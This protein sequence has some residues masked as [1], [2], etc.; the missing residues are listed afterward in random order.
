MISIR[1]IAGCGPSR[2]L[3]HT[4]GGDEEMPKCRQ[5]P[6]LWHLP[7]PVWHLGKMTLRTSPAAL[8]QAA[9]GVQEGN[10]ASRASA[11][12]AQS[13]PRAHM[14]PAKHS[15]KVPLDPEAS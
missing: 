7:G 14:H 12:S 15:V 11:H 10:L 8:C 4:E 3:P 13:L 2:V 6:G 1:F 5:A 9:C